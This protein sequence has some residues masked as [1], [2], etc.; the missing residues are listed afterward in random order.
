MQFGVNLLPQKKVST[1]EQKRGRS[2]KL[3]IGVVLIIYIVF[4][5]TLF[6]FNFYLSLSQK[7][8]AQ[9]IQKTETQ[10]KA[11]TKKETLVLTLKERAE[12]VAEILGN[13]EK[14]QAIE[15][16]QQQLLSWIQGLM[17]PGTNFAEA[18]ITLDKISFSGQADNAAIVGDFLEQFEQ[19][20]RKFKFLGI[21]SL[22]KSP[23]GNYSFSFRGEL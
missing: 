20:E 11:F 15:A 8:L 9:E 1:I 22:S 16:S 17:I 21:D 14:I 18:S 7:N 6:G 2:L 5:S 23:K 12:T 10:I 13:R 3:V 4:I 19:L